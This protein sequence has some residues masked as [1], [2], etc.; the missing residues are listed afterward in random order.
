[1]NGIYRH[2][3]YRGPLRP[4]L[5]FKAIQCAAPGGGFVAKWYRGC[6]DVCQE[7]AVSGDG[8]FILFPTITR[9]DAR[10]QPY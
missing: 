5:I 8:I 1:M 10:R 6:G 3:Y 7:K 2:H 4:K 9:E